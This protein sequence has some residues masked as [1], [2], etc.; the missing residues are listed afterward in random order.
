MRSV[1]WG[2]SILTAAVRWL[3]TAGLRLV[4]RYG[5]RTAGEVRSGSGGYTV[6]TTAV[7]A[8]GTICRLLGLRLTAGVVTTQR[9]IN[10]IRTA[11]PQ[12]HIARNWSLYM[13]HNHTQRI[14]L[15]CRLQQEYRTT[16]LISVSSYYMAICYCSYHQYYCP[17]QQKRPRRLKK[18]LST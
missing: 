10:T 9:R 12:R 3:A 1:C 15:R 17:S 13:H 8:A 16:I 14:R 5:G 18:A 2:Q 4:G 6:Q 11:A 7:V